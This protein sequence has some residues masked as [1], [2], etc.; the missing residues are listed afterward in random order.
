[1][2][3][4]PRGRRVGLRDE[5]VELLAREGRRSVLDLGSGPAGDGVAFR[6]AGHDYVGVDLA[7]ANARLAAE[8]GLPVVQGSMTTLPFRSSSF[9]A[10]WSLSALMHLDE[11]EASA[12]AGEI[13]R[14]LRPSA[15]FVVGLWGRE[16]EVSLV[17]RE[18]I[19]GSSRPFRLRSFER[20]RGLVSLVGELEM[21][22]RWEGA[23]EDWDY[24]IYRIRTNGRR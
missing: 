18:R 9:D 13:R 15:P 5:F 14:V 22:A 12:A 1:M 2:R 20:N 21:A 3:R 11:A 8:V 16:S 19:P 7:H 17:D 23:S 24:Q 6:A 10:G 4:A